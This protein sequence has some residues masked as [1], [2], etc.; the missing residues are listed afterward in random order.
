M[1]DSP[2]PVGAA[3]TRPADGLGAC[4]TWGELIPPSAWIRIAIVSALLLLVYWGPI[5]HALI[6]R[7]QNDGNWSHGWLIP[8]FALYFLAS[9]R[10]AL[11]RSRPRAN[12]IGAVILALSLVAYFVSA[13]QLRMAYPA[14]VSL[15]GAILG[16]TLLLGGWSVIRVAC[17]PILFLLMAIPLPQRVYVDLTMPLR[18]LASTVAAAVMPVFTPGLYTEAQAVVIDYAYTAPARPLPDGSACRRNSDCA[19]D[20]RSTEDVCSKGLCVHTR[21][22]TLN[23]EEA[24]SGMRS[25]M[26][27]LALGVAYAYLG[28]RPIWQRVVMVA[29]CVPIAI[30]CNAIRVTTTGLF[31]VHG[32]SDLAS[33]TPHAAFGVLMYGI[34]LGLFMLLGY[35][36]GHLFVEELDG[37]AAEPRCA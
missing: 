1:K 27:I 21:R 10:E 2:Q 3:S 15:V 23:V 31:I 8:A 9:K 16:V 19:D 28:D 6:W 18:R 12:Y 22:S 35:V 37:G 20:D 14:A 29:S 33:G 4:A 32:R 11:L 30:F 24:C 36:L 13:W 25:L 26:A 5:R 17:F 7:W 34:A